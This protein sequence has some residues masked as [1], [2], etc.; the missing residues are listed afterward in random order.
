MAGRVN[1]AHEIEVRFLALEP[2]KV[3]SGV[4]QWQLRLIVNQDVARSSRASRT[5]SRPCPSVKVSDCKPDYV[6]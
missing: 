1:L 4:A 2:D 6:G 5:N 3:Y